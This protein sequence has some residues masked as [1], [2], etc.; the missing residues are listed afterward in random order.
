MVFLHP[1]LTMFFIMVYVLIVYIIARLC[2]DLNE[3]APQTGVISG[4]LTYN[5]APVAG[6]T[7]T[8]Y[9]PD[10]TEAAVVTS[11]AEGKYA[12]PAMAVGQ[13]HLTAILKNPD[14]TWLQADQD[15]VIE[16]ATLVV[17]LVLV[18]AVVLLNFKYV[19]NNS[20]RNAGFSNHN[21]NQSDIHSFPAFNSHLL[22]FRFP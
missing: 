13:Y 14:G 2:P 19:E 16:E 20:N 7:V 22:F 21:I 9:N 1:N 8:L 18:S 6:A 10:G 15:V 17:D 5:G 12:L 11:D 3:P 4:G